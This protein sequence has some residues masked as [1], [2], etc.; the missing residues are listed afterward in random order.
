MNLTNLKRIAVAFEGHRVEDRTV[1]QTQAPYLFRSYDHHPHVPP[2]VQERNPGYSQRAR[3]WQVARATTA[4]PTYFDPIVID[5][6]RY[7]D[8]GF[9]ANNPI[10]EIYHEVCQMN[11][12]KKEC[13][14][15]LMSIGTGCPR[16]IDRYGESSIR[17]YFAFM[18]AARKLASDAEIAHENFHRTFNGQIP[19]HR[20]SVPYQENQGR[21]QQPAVPQKPLG[22]IKLDEWQ[23]ETLSSIRNAT[24]NYLSDPNV[25]EDLS[26]IAKR[27]VEA[28]RARSQTMHWELYSTGAEYRCMC[29]DC[30]HVKAHKIR[31]HDRNLR[32]HLINSHGIKEGQHLEDLITRGRLEY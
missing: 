24:E 18:K 15:L 21:T 17:K 11:G 20:F 16:R 27:L 32:S 2:Y 28:R 9:G 31:P 13:F 10:F 8:G 25:S 4:A 12:D 26:K 1:T 6:C 5:N 3:I 7:G 22:D 29:D 23:P 14:N 30:L 19:Y